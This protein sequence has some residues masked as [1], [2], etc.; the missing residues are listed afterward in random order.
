MYTFEKHLQSEIDQSVGRNQ[1]LRDASASKNTDTSTD[2]DTDT[3]E[4]TNTDTWWPGSAG[5]REVEERNNNCH[6]QLLQAVH[7]LT[8]VACPT[9]YQSEKTQLTSTRSPM[10]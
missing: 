8:G 2:T 6:R 7:T 1:D 10:L 3:N 5:Q 4:D 9:E